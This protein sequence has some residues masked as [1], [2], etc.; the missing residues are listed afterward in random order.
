[1]R[2][3]HTVLLPLS[4][5]QKLNKTQINLLRIR[6]LCQLLDNDKCGW[7]SRDL[8]YLNHKRLNLSLKVLKQY[9][10][11]CEKL[12]FLTIT[13]NRVYYRGLHHLLVKFQCSLKEKR[14]VIVDIKTLS[15]MRNWRAYLH[16][17][18]A[19]MLNGHTDKKV[20]TSTCKGKP[21]YLRNRETIGS[22]TNTKSVDAAIGY[23]KLTHT[24]RETHVKV[25]DHFPTQSLAQDWLRYSDHPDA[26]KCLIYCVNNRWVVCVVIG[27]RYKPLPR[28]PNNNRR[29]RIFSRANRLA[30]S[31][32]SAGPDPELCLLTTS[33]D[34]NNNLSNT[35]NVKMVATYT[36]YA[37]PACIH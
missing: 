17:Y 2:S 11:Q 10:R 20:A 31:G 21:L 3:T 6:V 32:M 29:K 22:Y 30:H 36:G 34:T 13:S 24:W 7:I 12:D 19:R 14:V 25:L 37:Q 33:N 15:N 1:M 16:S 9:L 8:L 27:V 4:L 23:E 5:L 35:T 26:H 18:I 28:K